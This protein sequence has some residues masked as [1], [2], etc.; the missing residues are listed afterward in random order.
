[1]LD[2]RMLPVPTLPPGAALPSGIPG[3]Q[4]FPNNVPQGYF[5]R[6]VS[7]T[8]VAGT[9]IDIEVQRPLGGSMRGP[10][11]PTGT[12]TY[13]TGP[14]VAVDNVSEVFDKDTNY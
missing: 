5:Y 6:V 14:L 3:V 11:G 4:Q 7:V 8:D 13:Y 12:G 2:A 10:Y 9:V 1:V